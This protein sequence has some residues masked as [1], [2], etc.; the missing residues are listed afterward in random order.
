MK[1][2]LMGLLAFARD[3]RRIS[4]SLE[5]LAEL[6]QLDLETRGIFRRDRSIKDEV[7]V[8]YGTGKD[9]DEDERER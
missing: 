6:Y 4:K 1:L 5:T 8:I 7:L 9:E 2:R 3:I